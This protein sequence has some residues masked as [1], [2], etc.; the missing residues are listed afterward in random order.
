MGP[1]DPNKVTQNVGIRH[2]A[3][4]L[5]EGC[6]RL[7][8]WDFSD[9]DDFPHA[10]EE[11]YWPVFGGENFGGSGGPVD[12]LHPGKVEGPH[13]GRGPRNYR[14]P[15]ERILEDVVERLTHHP[16]IDATDIQVSCTNG[17]V[18][19]TGTVQNREMKWMAEDEAYCVWGVTDVQNQLR[20]RSSRSSQQA[21]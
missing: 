11:D 10:H 4:I 3:N 20:I 8:H 12:W 19:L 17:E 16:W 13:R 15:D 5:L 21:A 6:M 14:R 9:D 1:R 7:W 18:T 2:A